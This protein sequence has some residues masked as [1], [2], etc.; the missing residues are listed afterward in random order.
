M[1][2]LTYILLFIWNIGIG[3]VMVV[4]NGDTTYHDRSILLIEDLSE[5]SG[6]TWIT[7][8]IPTIL[9]N[10]ISDTT[11]LNDSIGIY[12]DTHP[13]KT[14]INVPSFKSDTGLT[15]D[16]L[17]LSGNVFTTEAVT[18]DSL[19][20]YISTFKYDTVKAVLMVCDTID[21]EAG[22]LIK[23]GGLEQLYQKREDVFWVYGY[24]V[25]KKEYGYVS[26]CWTRKEELGTVLG[27]EMRYE[28]VSAKTIGYLDL[29]KKPFSKEILI[30]DYKIIE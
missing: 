23:A 3:Q 14:H 25:L 12:L 20:N 27:N 24:V 30:W 16:L 18:P 17:N 22:L 26:H 10:G 9:K 28:P 8:S 2:K 7:D 1:K 21:K 4:R 11:H 29:S 13:T 6:T 5:L 15:I 19:I